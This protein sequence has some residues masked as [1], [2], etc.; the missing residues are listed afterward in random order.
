MLTLGGTTSLALTGYSDSNYSNCA[1]TSKSVGGYCYS[2]GSGLISWS[3]RKQN[4]VADSSCYAEYITLHD[5]AHNA[6][7]LR[8]LLSDLSFPF[9]QPTPL[10]CDNDAATRLAEDHVWHSRTKHIWVKYHYTRKQVLEGSISVT[11][12][13]SSDNLADIFTKPLNRT[14]FQHL[15]HYLGLNQAP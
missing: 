13:R 1:E 7:F 8:Q 15:R 6:I 3:S 14:D 4:S 5:V 2:L 12:V 11:R 10:Y 9:T